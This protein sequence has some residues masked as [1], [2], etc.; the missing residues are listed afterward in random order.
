MLSQ[1]SFMVKNNEKQFQRFQ[2]PAGA[3]LWSCHVNGQP[4]K[5]ERDGVT[6]FWFP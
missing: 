4:A 3:A 2:L 5:P 1:A 6:G